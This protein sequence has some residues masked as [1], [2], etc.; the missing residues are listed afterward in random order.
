[1]GVISL[2]NNSLY[3]L[4]NDT[5]SCCDDPSGAVN[6]S[7]AE[8]AIIFSDGNYVREFSRFSQI[9]FIDALIIMQGWQPFSIKMKIRN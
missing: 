4:L 5:R 7:A 2:E 8:V 1:M 6:E 3:C 9:S